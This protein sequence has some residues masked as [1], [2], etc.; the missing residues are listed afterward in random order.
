M[1]KVLVI[2][3]GR[4][5]VSPVTTQV[6]ET[7]KEKGFASEFS[8]VDFHTLE[9]QSHFPKIVG[10]MEN[11]VVVLLGLK[12]ETIHQTTSQLNRATEKDPTFLIVAWQGAIKPNVCSTINPKCV[13]FFTREQFGIRA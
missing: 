3:I 11:P 5:L 8:D 9:N 2:G 4:Q 10:K 1:K 6:V 7:L 13:S 12:P